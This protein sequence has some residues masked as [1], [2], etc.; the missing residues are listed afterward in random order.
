MAKR[1]HLRTPAKVNLRLEVLYKRPDGYHELLT[2]IYPISLWDEVVIEE[3]EEGYQLI[4]DD[5]RLPEEDLCLKAAKAFSARFGIEKGVRIYLK[6]KI[7]IG[8]GLGGGSS[9]ASAVLKGMAR[10]FG[11]KAAFNELLD[12][13]RGIGSDVPF[14][15]YETPALMGGRGDIQLEKLPKLDLWLVVLY[16]GFEVS[17]GEVYQQLAAS[18]TRPRGENKIIMEFPPR[19]WEDFLRNDLEKVVEERFPEVREMKEFLRKEGAKGVLVSGSGSSVF[20]VFGGLEE[21]RRC[22]QRAKNSPWEAFLVKTV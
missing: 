16:P 10:L 9:D 11:L 14:F 1:V 6:K 5:P 18:L 3:K 4:C 2:W 15:L 22:Y 7:P 20:G 13:A 12:L 21:A 17:T 8:A 19:K